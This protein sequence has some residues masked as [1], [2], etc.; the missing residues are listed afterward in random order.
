[1]TRRFADPIAVCCSVVSIGL[2]LQYVVSRIRFSG[3]PLKTLLAV[4]GLAFF[5]LFFPSLLFSAIVQLFLK[6]DAFR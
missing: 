1:M 4:Q 5:L 3:P 6:K 2:S